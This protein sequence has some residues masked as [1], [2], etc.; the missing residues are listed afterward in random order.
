MC[1]SVNKGS[2]SKNR[3]KTNQIIQVSSSIVN[4]NSK[5]LIFVINNHKVKFFY[6]VFRRNAIQLL[7]V[8]NSEIGKI[9]K[10][11]YAYKQRVPYSIVK[12]Y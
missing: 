1:N 12:V 11:I 2:I 10:I 4:T 5:S 7:L 6:S 3:A 9:G 8:I